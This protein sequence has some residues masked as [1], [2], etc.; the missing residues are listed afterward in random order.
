MWAGSQ[1][2]AGPVSRP[3]LDVSWDGGDTWT[4]ARLPGLAGDIA[5][6]DYLLAAPVFFGD[7]GVVA[8]TIEGQDAVTTRIFTTADG[9]RTWTRSVST[10]EASDGMAFT[11]LSRTDWY[12]ES[13][14]GLMITRDAGQTWHAAGPPLEVGQI[15]WLSFEDPNRGFAIVDVR[16]DP[17]TN[18]LYATRDGGSSWAPA[19]LAAP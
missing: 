18:R 14:G 2:D 8:A 1:G 13:S 5:A 10:L 15:E 19:V 9:G 4:D 17:Y 16:G 6:P 7:D 12:L 3:I 11:P